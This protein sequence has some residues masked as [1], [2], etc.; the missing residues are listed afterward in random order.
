MAAATNAAIASADAGSSLTGGRR[1]NTTQKE[2]DR[3]LNQGGTE[4]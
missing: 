2:A 4:R 3:L 1:E